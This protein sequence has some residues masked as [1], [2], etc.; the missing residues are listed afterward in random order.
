[1]VNENGIEVLKGNVVFTERN[2][3]KDN[4]QSMIDDYLSRKRLDRKVGEAR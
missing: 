1:M 2:F 3:F 4:R